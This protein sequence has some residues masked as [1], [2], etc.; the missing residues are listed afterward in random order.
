VVRPDFAEAYS[1]LGN[2][3]QEQGRLAEAISNHERSIEINPQSPITSFNLALAQ[4][5][6]GDFQRGWAGYEWRWHLKERPPAIRAPR[7]DGSPLH[8]RTILIYLEQGLGDAIQ[9]IRF[10]PLVKA[11]GARVVLECPAFMAPLLENC[12]GIDQI[13]LEGS[14][15]P[16]VDVQAPL[17]SLPGI[18]GI[19]LQNLPAATRACV[20]SARRHQG[21]GPTFLERWSRNSESFWLATLCNQFEHGQRGVVLSMLMLM[22]STGVFVVVVVLMH[23]LRAPK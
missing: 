21:I 22:L 3:Y 20:C 7:W 23:F 8:G 13:I 12:Q 4:L 14:E 16:T 6:S 10:L 11:T 1:N 15:L 5:Q 18:L 9:F 2:L 19:T 17:M